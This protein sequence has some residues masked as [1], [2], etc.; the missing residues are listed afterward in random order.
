[1]KFTLQ[2]LS[3][4]DS[5]LSLSNECYYHCNIICTLYFLIIFLS[6][7][8]EY[9]YHCN[10][11]CTLYFHIIVL[12]LSGE[13]YFHCNIICTLYFLVN[14][15]INAMILLSSSPYVLRWFVIFSQLES[16]QHVMGISAYQK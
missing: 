4:E 6:L 1:M 8:L 16:S 5:F 7:S 10:T 9:Y 2:A 15:I 13:Y 3:V 14:I 11:I 12:S